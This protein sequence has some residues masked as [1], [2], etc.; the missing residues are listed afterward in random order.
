MHNL[1][2]TLARSSEKG[3]STMRALILQQAEQLFASRGFEGTSLDQIAE[4]VGIR[5]PSVLHHF[6]SKR[7]I[8]DLVEADI[9]ASLVAA[10]GSGNPEAPPFERLMTLLYGWLGAMLDRP[11]GARILLRNTADRTSRVSEDDPVQFIN[12]VICHFEAIVHAGQKD[13]SFRRVRSVTVLNI[14]SSSILHYVCCAD[15]MGVGRTYD[16]RDPA[17]LSEFKDGLRRAANGLLA[18]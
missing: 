17:L 1:N 16:P 18:G 8:Y 7:E 12:I 13:R 2:G 10:T 5:R 3:P 4:A 11:T 14:L 15:Q 9:V 6:R